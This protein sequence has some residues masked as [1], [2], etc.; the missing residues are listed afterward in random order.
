[1]N[2]RTFLKATAITTMGLPIGLPTFAK[3]KDKQQWIPFTEGVPKPGQKVIITS[4]PNVRDISYHIR[5]GVVKESETGIMHKDHANIYIIADFMKYG[6]T[7]PSYYAC[8]KEGKKTI[9]SREWLSSDKNPVIQYYLNPAWK[10]DITSYCLTN[11]FWLLVNGEYPVELPPIPRAEFQWTSFLQKMPSKRD[12]I[13]VKH[14]E[15]Y[16]SSG[17]INNDPTDF[18]HYCLAYYVVNG[19]VGKMT[20]SYAMNRI[21]INQCSWRYA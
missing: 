12:H 10:K 17:W 16:V 1:M 4:F 21:N 11:H 2:R 9:Q 18:S 20:D 8:S 15:G 3:A 19:E 5:G 7:V 14:P 13:M 6:K